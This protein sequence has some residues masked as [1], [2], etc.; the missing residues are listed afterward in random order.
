VIIK[1]S[2]VRKKKFGER[3][4]AA[5]EHHLQV[6]PTFNGDKAPQHHCKALFFLI[7][8]SYV[9]SQAAPVGGGARLAYASFVV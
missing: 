3:G 2:T 7:S 9:R 4:A 1:R 6:G 8:R 5:A